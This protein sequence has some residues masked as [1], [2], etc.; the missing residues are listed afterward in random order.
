MFSI[1]DIPDGRLPPPEEHEAFYDP[2]GGPTWP[3][4]DGI[5]ILGTPYGAPAFVEAYLDTNIGK[6]KEVLASI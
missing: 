2:E 6:H 4:S 3:E 5:I 1:H